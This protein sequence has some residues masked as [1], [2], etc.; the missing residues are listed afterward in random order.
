MIKL[1]QYNWQVRE[2]W[3][4]WCRQVP[5]NEL[6]RERTGGVGSILHTL[7][8]IVDVEQSWINALR[9]QPDIDYDFTSYA[10]LD[11]VRQF[12][13][14]C[15][16]DIENFLQKWSPE[17]DMRTFT[18]SR[19]GQSYSF[20]YG[21]VLRHVIAH[22]IHHVGQLSIWARELDLQPVSANLI[23]RGLYQ[24]R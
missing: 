4:D 19:N 14:A 6:L 2:D 7:F 1:F 24:D 22:E 3:F 16:P 5:E 13:T 8:H 17:M 9:E 10:T 18:R 23:F 20:K 15:R 21:E 12:S 11:R